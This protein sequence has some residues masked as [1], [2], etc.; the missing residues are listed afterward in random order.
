M[1]GFNVERGIVDGVSDCEK[2][3]V[4]FK[5]FKLCNK[6]K[7]DK[8]LLFRLKKSFFFGDL[9]IF[10]KEFMWLLSNVLD[11]IISSFGKER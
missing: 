6:L 1:K 3:F 8:K 9:F 2:S 7:L 5:K 11:S 10:K 4:M